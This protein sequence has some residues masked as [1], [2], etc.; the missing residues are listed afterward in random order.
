MA[1]KGDSMM[2]GVRRQRGG[3]WSTGGVGNGM[4]GT[5]GPGRT[6][7][8]PPPRR[9]RALCWCSMCCCW[10]LEVSAG[11]RASV[12]V[13]FFSLLLNRAPRRNRR[14]LTH[15]NGFLGLGSVGLSVLG[16]SL[17]L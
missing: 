8:A 16:L 12:N 13:Y 5:R 2:K 10:V 1:L 4:D 6:R 3:R 14:T 9:R 15:L 7:A 11:F 17:H